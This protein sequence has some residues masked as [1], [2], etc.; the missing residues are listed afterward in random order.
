MYT[1]TRSNLGSENN[2]DLVL[3]V[4]D[5]DVESK[6]ERYGCGQGDRQAPWPLRLLKSQCVCV[7]VCERERERERERECERS[8]PQ[9]SGVTDPLVHGGVFQLQTCET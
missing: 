8:A 9:R 1:T 7:C 4:E 2:V 5:F 3:N 6:F